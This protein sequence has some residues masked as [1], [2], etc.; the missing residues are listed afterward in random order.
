MIRS[1][2]PL[3]VWLHGRPV[4]E[5]SIGRG[6]GLELRY[7]P[8][9]VSEQ[10]EGTLGLS[11]PLPI[12]MKA[13]RGD[14]VDWW[15]EGLL[16]E[17]ETRTVLENYFDVRRGDSF[18]LIT[19][20]GRDCAG[21][22]AFTPRDEP[23]EKCEDLRPL[24]SADV[25]EAVGLLGTRPLG[26]DDETRVSLG[27]LQSKLLLVRTAGGWAR[28]ASGI[29]S[30]HILKPD[31]LE[32]PGLV[33][34]EALGQRAAKLAGLDAAEVTLEELGG[35]PVLI[36]ERFDRQWTDDRLVRIHQEDGCQALG[37]NPAGNH[38]YQGIDEEVS[39]RKLATV[40]RANAADADRELR[41]LGAMMTFTVALGNTDAHM[42][43]H[44]LLHI[45]AGVSLAP[46]YDA[47]PTVEFARTRNLGLWVN[48]QAMLVAVTGKHLVAEMQ[49]WGVT[50]QVARDTTERT[51]VR[52]L[53]ALPI[54]ADEFPQVP[55]RIV[56][57]CLV[58]VRRLLDG[59]P[60]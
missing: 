8:D 53:D 28:P 44:S 13:Y 52:L 37:T 4:G 19:A 34:S 17:G 50:S 54:A 49:A 43:N 48:D 16:P 22:V 5:L 24:S 60:G 31:P 38:K 18:G 6:R 2:D 9:F 56:D 35:R 59:L 1:R 25:V 36:V 27:G 10:G 23:L 57:G 20:I 51:L 58:R 39:Y 30:T 33:P 40:I 41:R 47:A 42:R 11:I 29:P 14:V 12:R 15:V 7:R 55:P 32:F 21:A 26:V 46:V 45:D 3:T